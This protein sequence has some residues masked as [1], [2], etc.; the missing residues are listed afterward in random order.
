MF[1]LILADNLYS[2]I[3]YSDSLN[4]RNFLRS[5][6]KS[7]LDSQQATIAQ[8]VIDPLI[9][10]YLPYLAILMLNIRIIAYLKRSKK[11][12]VSFYK[13]T[14]TTIVIDFIYLVLNLP[15][16]IFQ[17]FIIFDL[18]IS[19][20]HSSVYSLF[21]SLSFNL[22]FTYPVALFFIFA[23]FNMVFRKE[24]IAFFRLDHFMN[25]YFFGG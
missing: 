19:N 22:T 14:F 2:F 3:L 5:L 6:V 17:V 12:I 18:S 16:K 15:E 1:G 25:K 24:L 4:R 13:F 20:K 8:K 10:F 21:R 9:K 23:V 11:W 7:C